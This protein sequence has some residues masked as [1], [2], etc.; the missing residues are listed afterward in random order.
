MIE[1]EEKVVLY[2]IFIEFGIPMKLVRLIKTSSN[3]PA[4]KVRIGKRLSDVF[5]LRNGLKQGDTLSL[6]LF[7]FA[8]QHAITKVQENRRD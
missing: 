4:S 6:L 7:N 5:L 1:L 3:K 8:L 2:N